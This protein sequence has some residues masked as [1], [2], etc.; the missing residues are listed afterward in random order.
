MSKDFLLKVSEKA[1]QKKLLDEEFMSFLE[2]RFPD[3]IHLRL[4]DDE[5]LTL[6]PVHYIRNKLLN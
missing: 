4:D 2:G 6:R 3:K 1:K 5:F